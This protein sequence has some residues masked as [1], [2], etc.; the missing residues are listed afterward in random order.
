MGYSGV[1]I[2]SVLV[3]HLLSIDQNPLRFVGSPAN[4][5]DER[6]RLR[7]ITMI[8]TPRFNLLHWSEKAPT[9]FS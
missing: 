1:L 4:N 7:Q 3:P 2:H 5:L 6:E 9:L 8:P